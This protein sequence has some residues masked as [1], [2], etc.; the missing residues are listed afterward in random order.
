M[1]TPRTRTK[2]PSLQRSCLC[3]SRT[4]KRHKF[5]PAC[6]LGLE[7]CWLPEESDAQGGCILR[8]RNYPL[9]MVGNSGDEVSHSSPSF[10][11]KS[12]P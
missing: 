11:H 4:N 7:Q 9:M 8:T 10:V 3:I 6:A 5:S 2:R 1:R 12:P